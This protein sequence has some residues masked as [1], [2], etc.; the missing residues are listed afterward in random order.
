MRVVE[1]T[2]GSKV[3]GG[4]ALVD[5]AS[6]GENGRKFTELIVGGNLDRITVESRVSQALLD[7]VD[8]CFATDR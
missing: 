1:L 7:I 4:V 6:L 5:K 8:C 2:V 3:F